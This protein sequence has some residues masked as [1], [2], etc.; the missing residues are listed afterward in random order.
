MP[1]STTNVTAG[2]DLFYTTNC[3]ARLLSITCQRSLTTREVNRGETDG[4][5]STPQAHYICLWTEICDAT[6]YS[7]LQAYMSNQENYIFNIT[8]NLEKKLAKEPFHT[9]LPTFDVH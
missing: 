3:G 1:S 2:Q 4:F 7:I 6:E 8:P 9:L 5:D